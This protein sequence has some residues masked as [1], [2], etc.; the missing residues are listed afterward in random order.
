M[1]FRCTLKKLNSSPSSHQVAL[2]SISHFSVRGTA[3]HLVAQEETRMSP[4]ILPLSPQWLKSW[5]SVL[6]EVLGTQPFFSTLPVIT[7]VYTII[8]SPL[9]FSNCFLAGL[10]GSNFKFSESSFLSYSQRGFL[11][12]KFG[13][14]TPLFKQLQWLSTVL[15]G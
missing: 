6:L 1:L 8:V 4:Q 12:H 11:K 10:P 7:T 3:I 2:L 14:I 13:Q 9:D 5:Q 15:K